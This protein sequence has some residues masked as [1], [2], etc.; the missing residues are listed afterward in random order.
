M[1]AKRGTRPGAEFF[2]MQAAVGVTKHTGGYE[3]TQELLRLCHVT[4]AHSVLDVGCGIG[5]GPAYIA[6]TYGCR[7][8]GVDLSEPMI[9]WAGRRARQERVDALVTL[10]T[11]DVLDLPF[12]DSSFDVVVCESVLAFVE[13]KS[14]AI[15]ECVRVTRPGGYVGLNEGLWLKEPPAELVDRVKDAIGPCVP[16]EEAWQDLWAASGLHDRVVRIRRVEPRAEMK[17]RVRWIGWRWIVRAWGRGLWFYLKDPTTR[18]SIKALFDVPLDVFEFAGYGLF[19]G[20]KQD[21]GPVPDLMLSPP[22]RRP[23]VMLQSGDPSD[24]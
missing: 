19:V 16:T 10:R 6:K 24:P 4:E 17:S 13:D 11:A 8:T 1:P 18:Q 22:P 12:P 9:R 20:K 5:V 15:R 23:G 3:A 14:R 21:P 2:D 7:A